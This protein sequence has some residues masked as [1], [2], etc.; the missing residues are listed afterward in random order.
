MFIPHG[1]ETATGKLKY[2][3]LI[4]PLIIWE[5]IFRK[6]E[7]GLSI[8]HWPLFMRWV[9]YYAFIW[10]IFYFMGAE[11]EFIYFQF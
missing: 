7:H 6:K 9:S 1:G 11:Q 8:A 2:L 10:L 4:F 5:W 3:A